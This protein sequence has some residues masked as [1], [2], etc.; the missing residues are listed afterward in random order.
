GDAM[1]K[2][3]TTVLFDVD[4]TLL[5]FHRDEYNALKATLLECKLP[6]EDEIIS[7]YSLINA[8]LWHAHE[9]GELTKEDI[10]NIRFRELFSAFDFESILTPRQVNDFYEKN[11]CNGSVVIDGAYDVCQ[12]LSGTYDLYIVTNGIEAT[13]RSRLGRSGFDKL[14]KDMFIS[15]AIGLQKPSFEFFDYVFAHISE[16][17]KSKVILVGD[18]L[19]SDIKGAIDAGIDC[20]WF[21]KNGIKNDTGLQPTHEISKIDEIMSI[22]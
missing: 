2:K 8:N 15:E 16:G 14:M 19:S 4:D 13:Q 3:Y 9:K 20:I 6:A 11:L 5:D 22:L 18:S 21:N 12:R 1:P 17:D 7:T 10:K